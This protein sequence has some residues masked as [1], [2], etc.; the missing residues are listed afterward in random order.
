MTV[1]PSGAKLIDLAAKLQEKY[2]GSVPQERLTGPVKP[3]CGT[4]LM[5]AIPEL[6]NGTVR[7]VGLT[8]AVKPGVA[9]V[10]ASCAD[11]LGA[12]VVSPR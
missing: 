12:K 11:W 9:M 2:T 1:A 5:L 6:P 3:P 10:T 7:L 4:R 8:V